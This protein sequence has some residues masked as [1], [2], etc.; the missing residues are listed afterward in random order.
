[1]TII[2]TYDDP[3]NIVGVPQ[4]KWEAR[5]GKPSGGDVLR[6]W[7]Y[8]GPLVAQNVLCACGGQI[9]PGVKC[10]TGGKCSP[11][12]LKYFPRI[13]DET[14]IMFNLWMG[15]AYNPCGSP[16]E[17]GQGAAHPI[18][19]KKKEV[20]IKFPQYKIPVGSERPVWNSVCT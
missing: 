2:C 10:P 12:N 8:S 18:D 13:D 14:Y 20:L 7:N 3:D 9:D 11:D 17:K 19:G 16:Y 1:M 15:S 4:I 6:P 5:L